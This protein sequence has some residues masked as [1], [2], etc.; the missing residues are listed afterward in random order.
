MTDR[1]DKLADPVRST[2]PQALLRGREWICAA[3]GCPLQSIPAMERQE[4][5]HRQGTEG[6]DEKGCRVA[7]VGQ[8]HRS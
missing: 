7:C 3:C 2:L 5:V 1:V 6:R 8:I 4:F